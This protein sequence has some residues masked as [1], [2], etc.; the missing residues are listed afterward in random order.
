MRERIILAHDYQEGSASSNRVLG[1]AKGYCDHGKEVIVMLYDPSGKQSL[2]LDKVE[3]HFF[4]EPQLKVKVLRRVI[5][6]YK[7]VKAIKKVYIPHITFIH[8]YRTPWWGFLS[9]GK[10]TIS[11]LKEERFHS[12]L[13]RVRWHID[14]KSI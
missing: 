5:G 3:V 6:I 12:I 8:I 4:S 7:Y 2:R 9:A 13:T 14:C 1:F 11:F 10:S